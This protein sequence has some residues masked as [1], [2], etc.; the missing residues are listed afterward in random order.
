MVC[1]FCKTIIESVGEIKYQR[2]AK[3]L[4]MLKIMS[5][6]IIKTLEA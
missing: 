3:S 5:L 4:N 2:L 1:H 6:L